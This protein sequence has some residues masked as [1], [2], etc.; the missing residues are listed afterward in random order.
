M[1]VTDLLRVPA[2]GGTLLLTMPATAAE[3]D[4]A[5]IIA[6]DEIVVT[7]A[8]T[9]LPAN[10]LP[11]TVDVI[12]PALLAQQVAIGG[13]I[14]DAISTLTPSFS[15]TRQK[16]SGAGETLRGRSP[17]FATNG[18]RKRRRCAMAHATVTPSTR[19]SSIGSRSSMAQRRCR[20]SAAPAG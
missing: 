13:S 4:A 10:A 5:T 15:P 14:I 16:L 9:I 8:R 7:A 1:T 19:F 6:A 17:L 3:A 18:I 12:D 11:L 20:G 2:C